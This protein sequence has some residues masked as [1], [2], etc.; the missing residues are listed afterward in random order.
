MAKN[1]KNKSINNQQIHNN[2]LNNNNQIN[3]SNSTQSQNDLLNNKSQI[4]FIAPVVMRH[5]TEEEYHNLKKENHDLQTK[6][7][8]LT[9]NERMLQ[10][11]KNVV[12]VLTEEKD[13]L[14]DENKELKKEND[15]LRQENERLKQKISDL[16]RKN[17]ILEQKVIKL[18]N[19]VDIIKKKSDKSD[20][21]IK[22]KS[23]NDIINTH[24]KKEYKKTFKPK[25]GENIP[26]I[27]EFINDPPLKEDD[28]ELF[29]FWNLFK[30]THSGC[31]NMQFRK[32]YTYINTQRNDLAHVDVS[33]M[34]KKEF[35]R[36]MKIVY[37]DYD[38]NKELYVQYRNWSFTFPV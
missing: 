13:N 36:L 7:L 4:T 27:G 1:K 2:L 22:L 23:C 11:T 10:E 26:N 17:F 18:E 15:R 6:F 32:I 34:D 16:E 8:T 9:N 14:L 35:D 20:A 38:N 37:D 12:K 19:I 5:I 28:E 31:D 24:F 29:N 21:L 25:R 3:L 33:C 30:K